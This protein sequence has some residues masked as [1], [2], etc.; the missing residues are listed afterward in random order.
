MRN[1]IAIA[2]VS[3]VAAA[4]RATARP[5]PSLGASS[6]A[7]KAMNGV[8]RSVSLTRVAMTNFDGGGHADMH[9][10]GGRGV[11][12][13]PH[14]EALRH[15]HPVQVPADLGQVRPILIRR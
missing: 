9:R 4:M 3:V 5:R 2:T 7:R 6:C 10:L 12:A 14:R 8:R 1:T 13:D 15:D 11:E